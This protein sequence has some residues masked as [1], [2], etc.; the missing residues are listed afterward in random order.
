MAEYKEHCR[1]CQEEIGKAWEVVHR[2]L[3]EFAFRNGVFRP[4]HRCMRHHVG[5]V[6]EVRRMWGDE[7]AR[8][9]EIHIRKDFG[10]VVPDEKEVQRWTL[11]G[12]DGDGDGKTILTDGV[13]L[14]V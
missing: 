14:R 1:D 9:A 2:W 5:G 11:C 8:A 10:G 7:A 3:D 12:T 6:A 4:Q 13:I